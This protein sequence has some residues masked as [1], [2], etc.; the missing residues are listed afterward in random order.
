M[1]LAAG[2]APMNPCALNCDRDARIG[3]VCWQHHDQL[4]DLLD[5]RNHGTVYNP[6]RP[7]DVQVTASIP[8]LYGQ[9]SAERGR[10]GLV[11]I[12]SAAFGSSSPADDHVIVLRDP[13]S[14]AEATGP[15]DV[16]LAPRPPLVVL[17]TIAYRI[18]DERGNPEREPQ[19]TTPGLSAWLYGALGWI[20]AQP[21]VD[22]AWYELRGLSR[23]LR[24]ANGDPV[25]GAVGTCR[26][27]V[28]DDGR[29]DPAGRWRCA[30]PLHMPELPPRAPD[31]PIQ[32]PVLR[33][34]SCRHVYD[35]ASLVQLGHEPLRQAS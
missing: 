31:E 32:L 34:G 21:W 17:E 1:R 11:S 3:R 14:R 8:V 9:M 2:P 7:D 28:N 22:A 4:A 16:E 13:R 6:A 5:P 33:C 26:A 24:A 23:A 30:M 18:I 19:W 20:V 27:I 15:D 35:A 29:E 25:P 10:A 12:G